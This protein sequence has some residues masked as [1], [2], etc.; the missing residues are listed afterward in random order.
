MPEREKKN[1][2]YPDGFGDQHAGTIPNKTIIPPGNYMGEK[3]VKSKILGQPLDGT[4][5][6]EGQNRFIIKNGKP[7]DYPFNA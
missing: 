7:V 3:W 6:F 4:V 2:V 5:I 1:I